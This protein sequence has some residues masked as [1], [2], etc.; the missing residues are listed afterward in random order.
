VS[1]RAT[2]GAALAVALVALVLSAT[3]VAQ[4]ATKKVKSALRPHAVLRLDSHAKVPVKA[5]PKV[6]S[7][8]NADTLQGKKLSDLTPGCGP[9]S[10]DVGTWCLMSA[11]YPVANDE[12]GK[13]DYLWASQKCE[14]LGGWLPTAAQ[15]VGAASRA[16]LNSTIND[17]ATTAAVD[18]YPGDGLK[19]KRE[20]SA[21]LVTTAAGSSSAGSQGVSEGSKGNPGP[22]EPDPVPAPADPTPSTLQYVTVYDNGNKGG[23]AGSKPVSQPEDFR[24]AFAKSPGAGNKSSD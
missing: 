14:A 11:V 9:D 6:R 8:V 12:V 5:L 17:N 16:R 22:G 15:L 21:T 23:F 3:G 19:D 2:S 18:E 20:M 10:I 13:N 1:P 7:A 24:C 4:S